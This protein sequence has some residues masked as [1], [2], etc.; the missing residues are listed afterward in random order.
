MSGA[1]RRSTVSTTDWRQILHLCDHLMTPG[2]NNVAFPKRFLE[3]CRAPFNAS[4]PGKP[5]IRSLRL[6]EGSL[7]FRITSCGVLL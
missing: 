2:S 1:L 3:T 7:A 4:V 6:L 5:T